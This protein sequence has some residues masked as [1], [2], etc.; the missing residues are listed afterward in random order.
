MS[1]YAISNI[2]H[3]KWTLFQKKYQLLTE[4]KLLDR[5][6][7]KIASTAL[8]QENRVSIVVNNQQS[9]KEEWAPLTGDLKKWKAHFPGN[10]FVRVFQQADLINP[11]ENPPRL[12][13]R[14]SG[15][16]ITQ[17]GVNICNRRPMYGSKANWA[18]DSDEHSGEYVWI[19]RSCSRANWTRSW[20]MHLKSRVFRTH[21]LEKSLNWCFRIK[22]RY[23]LFGEILA[24]NA[25]SRIQTL[26]MWLVSLFFW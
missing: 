7:S 6:E 18:G 25:F 1:V 12:G 16:G 14:K 13:K 5:P 4:G 2:H 10:E 20:R 19:T 22:R 23:I 8:V 9:V 26:K 21:D 17:I 24:C 3:R 15:G 11:V